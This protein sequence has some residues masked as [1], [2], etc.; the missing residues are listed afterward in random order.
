MVVS[1]MTECSG[2]TAKFDKAYSL[3]ESKMKGKRALQTDFRKKLLK[4]IRSFE[5][6]MPLVSGKF[7]LSREF[8]NHFIKEHGLDSA[9]S[10]S[11]NAFFKSFSALKKHYLVH[12]K[13]AHYRKKQSI[14]SLNPNMA[15]LYSAGFGYVDSCVDGKKAISKGYASLNPS[16]RVKAAYIDL[17]LYQASP[18]S[19][20]ELEKIGQDHIIILDETS[21]II[22]VERPSLIKNS[23]PS[24]RLVNVKGPRIISTLCE[25]LKEGKE[26]LF[27]DLSLEGEFEKHRREHYGALSIS[28]IKMSVANAR[29]CCNSP[30]YMTIA[31][32]RR[33]TS[34]STLSEMDILY[35]GIIPYELME[36]EKQRVLHALS[37]PDS[38]EE[39]IESERDIF[40]IMDLEKLQILLKSKVSDFRPRI[41]TAKNE[42]IKL[43]EDESV[44]EHVRLIVSYILYLLERVENR[45]KIAITTFKGY[46]GILNNHLFKNVEDLNQVQA[47][48]LD[49]ILT[50]LERLQY[51]KKTIR[52][53][54]ALMLIFFSFHSK[55]HRLVGMDIHS[56]PK[57]LIFRQE[58]DDILDRIASDTC[59][60]VKRI[61]FRHRFNIL[62]H[63]ALVLLGFYTGLRKNELR[64]RLLKDIY[65]LDSDLCIDVN[66][67]GMKKLG[68]K[69]KTS[70]AKRRVCASITN[71]KH[72]A[73]IEEFLSHRSRV[74]NRSPYLFLEVSKG[75]NI[76]RSKA[77]R[78]SDFDKLSAT[79]QS[80]TGRYVS[81]HSLR[82]S[83]ATYE[84][85]KI[86]YNASDKPYQLLDL[87]VRMGHESADT[88]LKVYT[89]NSVVS[90][91]GGAECF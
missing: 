86:L 31:S 11:E 90:Q 49:T 56:Y 70:N 38:D 55:S 57:S 69:L 17:R 77:I 73:L 30:L 32:G 71:E 54:R 51:K 42:L 6:S 5:K 60:D 50:N 29:L 39:P 2:T 81:F 10:K 82:H 64:S 12:K 72:L 33:V 75:S 53:I 8:H 66:E 24:Y 78:E 74:K 35:P 47:H 85:E 13:S 62:Q 83:Y 27:S 15:S 41:K 67:H 25:T 65:I 45:K 18:L 87:A 28:A 63:Q 58:L 23:I 89:H 19:H 9:D 59:R 37:R 61:G 14:I 21:A 46:I 34:P 68:L 26:A 16:D 43:A 22:Y 44:S 80:I 48:E 79:M 52:K 36:A 88:T 1:G 20:T 84:V 40:S 4:S 76:I 7:I 91:V 3:L